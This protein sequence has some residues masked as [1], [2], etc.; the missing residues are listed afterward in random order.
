MGPCHSTILPCCWYL[1]ILGVQKYVNL[2]H[3]YQKGILIISNTI[4]N[5]RLQDLGL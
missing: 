5:Y 3:I 2:I 4:K 1:N